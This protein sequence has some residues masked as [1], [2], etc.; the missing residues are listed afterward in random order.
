MRSTLL[1]IPLCCAQIVTGSLHS[2]MVWTQDLYVLY[3][4]RNYHICAPTWQARGRVWGHSQHC[5]RISSPVC[6]PG[7]EWAISAPSCLFFF[8]YSCFYEEPDDGP[9]TS[10]LCILKDRVPSLCS[11]MEKLFGPV[12]ITTPHFRFCLENFP[13]VV[14]RLLAFE[15]MIYYFSNLPNLSLLYKFAARRFLPLFGGTTLCPPFTFSGVPPRG[16]CKS[17]VG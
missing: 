1:S 5:D 2:K 7:S 13:R 12:D 9:N 17:F 16:T 6:A 3:L 14:G 15:N 8:D 4:G 10:V 11:N